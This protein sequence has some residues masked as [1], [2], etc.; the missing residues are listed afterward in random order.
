MKNNRKAKG[1]D[2]VLDFAWIVLNFLFLNLYCW[3]IGGW[4]KNSFPN[5]LPPFNT[6]PWAE[7]IRI[8]VDVLQGL[9]FPYGCMQRSRGFRPTEQGLPWR[10][11]SGGCPCPMESHGTGQSVEGWRWK[12]ASFYCCCSYYWQIADVLI[13]TVATNLVGVICIRTQ[14]SHF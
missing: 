14:H 5:S 8:W 9:L 11:S 7:W 6:L 13:K 4:F 2:A 1:E 10:N 3:V 12:I